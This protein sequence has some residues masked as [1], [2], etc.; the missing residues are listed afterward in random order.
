MFPGHISHLIKS[1]SHLFPV[2]INPSVLFGT[3]GG[4]GRWVRLLPVRVNGCELESEPSLGA[5][6]DRSGSI[7]RHLL[8]AVQRTWQPPPP[9]TRPVSPRAV[10]GPA[11]VGA[12]TGPDRAG[13]S[14]AALP[15]YPSP[16]AQS[17]RGSSSSSRSSSTQPNFNSF[18]HTKV[19]VCPGTAGPAHPG[20][21]VLP[22]SSPQ[23]HK[24][25]LLRPGLQARN[26]TD[27]TGTARAFAGA[28]RTRLSSGGLA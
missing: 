9:S 16:T 12:W 5:D 2:Q 28:N 7:V 26:R 4:S 3:Q 14:A 8:A 23:K 1:V 25:F 22:P 21:S 24:E 13:V 6:P 18:C 19:P 17:H 20:R 15:E 27:A 11:C 10:H